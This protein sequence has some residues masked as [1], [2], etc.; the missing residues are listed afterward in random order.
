MTK[1][2]LA[3]GVLAALGGA[4]AAQTIPSGGGTVSG[5]TFGGS[6]LLAPPCDA[7]SVNHPEVIFAWTP[8]VVGVATFKVVGGVTAGGGTPFRPAIYLLESPTASASLACDAV[9]PR[10][11]TAEMRFQVDP[12][13][14]GM[15]AYPTYYVVVDGSSAMH[16]TKPTAG[17]FTLTITMGLTYGSEELVPSLAA[18]LSNVVK[19]RYHFRVDANPVQPPGVGLIWKIVFGF[20]FPTGPDGASEFQANVYSDNRVIYQD[21]PGT[22]SPPTSVGGTE[23]TL[24]FSIPD[25]EPPDALGRRVFGTRT[26][27]ATFFPA[28][29]QEIDHFHDLWKHEHASQAN[30]NGREGTILVERLGL[31]TEVNGLNCLAPLQPGSRYVW[32]QT[33]TLE[34]GIPHQVEFALPA[35][36]AT[37]LQPDRPTNLYTEAFYIN[38]GLFRVYYWDLEFAADGSPTWSPLPQWTTAR[39]DIVAQQNT[40]GF[41]LTNFRGIPAI[42]ASNDRTP[43]YLRPGEI[44][45][46]SAVPAC[47]PAPKPSCAQPGNASLSL[48][49][50]VLKP[51]KSAL[52]LKW[53]G[54]TGGHALDLGDPLTT[55][56]YALCLYHEPSSGPWHAMTATAPAGGICGTR[57]CWKGSPPLSFKYSDRDR[58][59]AGIKQLQV[60]A[61]SAG[62]ASVKLTG[63]GPSLPLPSLPL[64]APVTVQVQAT[65]GTCWNAVFYDLVTRNDAATFTA[66]ADAP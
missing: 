16:A 10:H 37:Y 27:D 66:R 7:P 26:L 47:T 46:L 49:R 13:K 28:F 11:T 53:S 2:M 44:L 65:N 39:T 17:T 55:T 4:G 48:K 30:L 21:V 25:V 14:E 8:S 20:L 59:P 35:G 54:T 61:T 36:R 22:C 63:S 6:A 58:T 62:T 32:R 51:A 9:G 50:N 41:R 12:L 43:T 52:T 3:L 1:I 23:A 31:T 19:L 15:T 56:S 33:F 18:P 5:N 38:Y 34:D 42:E 45:D 57:S 60:V 64:S 40:W 29:T 24:W